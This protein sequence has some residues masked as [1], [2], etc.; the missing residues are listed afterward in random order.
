MSEQALDIYKQLLAEEDPD[1]ILHTYAAACLYYMG[2]YEE[3]EATAAEVCTSCCTT[4]HHML[5]NRFL[6]F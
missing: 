3:A 6:R 4:P 5:P 1:P 2:L